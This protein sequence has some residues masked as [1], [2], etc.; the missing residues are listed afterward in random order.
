KNV[1]EV[2]PK[3]VRKNNDAPIIEDWVS[4]DEEQDESKT[5]PEKKTVIPT[6]AKIEKPIK[7]LV[8]IVNTARSYRTPVNTVR[9]RIVNTATMLQKSRVTSRPV[10]HPVACNRSRRD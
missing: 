3:K 5:K 2:E 7:N 4:D 10:D 9:P 6:A 1:S 8:R